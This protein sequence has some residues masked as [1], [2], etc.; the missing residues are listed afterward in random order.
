MADKA[1]LFWRT[2]HPVSTSRKVARKPCKGFKMRG[3]EVKRRG[4]VND[5]E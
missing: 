4:V 3:D 1:A 2:T 5:Q